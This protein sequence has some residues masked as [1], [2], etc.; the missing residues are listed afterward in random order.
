MREYIDLVLFVMDWL[1]NSL[2]A[3]AENMLDFAKGAFTGLI[4]IFLVFTMPI[5]I[6]PY[7]IWK[8]RRNN[9]G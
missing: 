7:L 4:F 3:I 2:L 1:V 8:S 6:V 5:W 9:D